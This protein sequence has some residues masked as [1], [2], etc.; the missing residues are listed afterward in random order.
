MTE[1]EIDEEYW[2]RVFVSL[3]L[4]HLWTIL[5]RCLGKKR[6]ETDSITV[7]SFAIR[8][9]YKRSYRLF[10]REIYIHC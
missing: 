1:S 4:F 6:D 2:S 9:E 7:I 10:P 8:E 5:Y 3:S